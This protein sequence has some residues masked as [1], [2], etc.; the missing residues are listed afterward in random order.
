MIKNEAHAAQERLS[1]VSEVFSRVVRSL[2]FFLVFC[3]SPSVLLSFFFGHCIV[4]PAI[5][6]FGVP[7]LYLQ[8]FL[9]LTLGGSY[10]VIFKDI[11]FKFLYQLH[12]EYSVLEVDE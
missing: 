9:V 7:L 8:T 3:G 2:V 4:C 10:L 5:Y 12:H 1:N 6:E 11:L